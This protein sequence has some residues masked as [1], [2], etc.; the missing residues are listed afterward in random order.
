MKRLSSLFSTSLLPFK[1]RGFFSY[2]LMSFNSPFGVFFTD[3]LSVFPGVSYVLLLL[4]LG[5]SKSGKLMSVSIDLRKVFFQV[6]PCI[7]SS[8]AL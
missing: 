7:I 1:F 3:F 6:F 8:K 2:T 4:L 5:S